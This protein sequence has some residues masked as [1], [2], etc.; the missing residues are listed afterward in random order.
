MAAHTC[1]KCGGTN[2]TRLISRVAIAKPSRNYTSMSSNEMM[3]VMEGG[4]SREL[5]GMMRQFGDEY[6]E[7]GQ[8][9][10]EVAERLMKGEDPERVEKDLEAQGGLPGMDDVGS[11]MGML[12]SDDL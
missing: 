1:P 8:Q 6:P 12:G 2:L 7:L 11:G 10:G 4:D 5:G 3:N 9:Y